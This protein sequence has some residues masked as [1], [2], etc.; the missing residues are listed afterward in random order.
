MRARLPRIR[1]HTYVRGYVRM[2]SFDCRRS[3]LGAASSGQR[4]RGRGTTLNME[5][6]SRRARV[7]AAQP[8]EYSRGVQRCAGERARWRR[9]KTCGIPRDGSV[10]IL[11]GSLYGA[12]FAGIEGLS[13]PSESGSNWRALHAAK[14]QKMIIAEQM[15]QGL[16]MAMPK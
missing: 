1:A 5:H 15:E 16:S 9:A 11:R 14:F 7:S 13:A 2:R 6:Q 10:A 12:R 4:R 8:R 3:R